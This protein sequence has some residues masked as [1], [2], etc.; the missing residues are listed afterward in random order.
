MNI[1]FN[2]RITHKI[3]LIGLFNFGLLNPDKKKYYFFFWNFTFDFYSPQI[4]ISLTL[5][6][7]MLLMLKSWKNVN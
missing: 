4:R 2:S 6:F 3:V 5:E 1:I 7:T